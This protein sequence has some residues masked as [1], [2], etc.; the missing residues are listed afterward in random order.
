VRMFWSISLEARSLASLKSIMRRM[1]CWMR[2]RMSPLTATSSSTTV[3]T[4]Q[5]D[6]WLLSSR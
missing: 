6:V 5:K 2:D 4:I 3:R 1:R